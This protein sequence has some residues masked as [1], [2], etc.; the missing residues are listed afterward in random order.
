MT[1]KLPP[2][3]QGKRPFNQL[4]LLSADTDYPDIG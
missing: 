3:V 2:A 4:A 1:G